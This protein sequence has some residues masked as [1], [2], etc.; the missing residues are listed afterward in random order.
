VGLG[1]IVIIGGKQEEFCSTVLQGTA[2]QALLAQPLA[3]VEVMGRSMIERTIE[4]WLSAGAEDVSVLVAE[5][6][7]EIDR[8]SGTGDNVHTQ[9]VADMAAGVREILQDY[10]HRGIE[11]SFIVSA[12][13]YAETDLLDFF[14]F[15]REAR[16]TVTRALDA[17]GPLDLWVVT[18]AQAQNTNLADL[19]LQAKGSSYFVREYVNRLTH[20]R[21]LRRFASDVL[22]GRC[23]IRPSGQEIKP[24][25]WIDMGAE[26][27]RRARIVAP[28][29]IG[30]GSRVRE[31]TLITR[32]S[33]VETGCHVDAGTVVED[34][35][36]L[37][38]THVGLWL[39]VCHA[40]ANGNKL[41]S[42]ERDVVVEI[43]DASVMRSNAS[44]RQE[45]R[46]V[47]GLS[48][49]MKLQQV[50]VD[51]KKETPAPESWQLGANPIQ[52]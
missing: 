30:R 22:R 2:Q 39:D 7:G 47:V 52:G 8:L 16:Q 3:C 38:N 35:S 9:V 20:P 1:A 24:G 50:A 29:Y 40:M 46:A 43:S 13:V 33:N 18:C 37:A 45:T 48:R 31:D 49:P 21:D 23:A 32:C 34:S 15:H 51:S 41:L 26:V 14:Y 17:Q 10:V 42:L 25:V 19:L 4:R 28:A 36:I 44:V 11:H 27:H 6:V 12:N 5:E